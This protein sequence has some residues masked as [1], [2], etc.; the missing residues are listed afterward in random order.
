MKIQ[1]RKR[2]DSENKNVLISENLVKDIVMIDSETVA[3]II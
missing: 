1:I 2:S 3:Y